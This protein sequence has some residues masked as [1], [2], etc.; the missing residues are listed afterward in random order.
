ML[1][2]LWR[3]STWSHFYV[4][5][6]CVCVGT[7]RHTALSFSVCL[8][9]NLRAEVI[10]PGSSRCRWDGMGGKSVQPETWQSLTKDPWTRNHRKK[11]FCQHTWKKIVRIQTSIFRTVFGLTHHLCVSCF[12]ST[13]SSQ[14]FS[15][16]RGTWGVCCVV[17]CCV[18][19]L[20]LLLRSKG[21]APSMVGDD[22][23][24]CDS[25]WTFFAIRA[26]GSCSPPAVWRDG[27]SSRCWSGPWSAPHQSAKTGDPDPPPTLR[28]QRD[29]SNHSSW[30]QDK[31]P[32]S[33]KTLR[34]HLNQ[35][36]H[37]I[38]WGVSSQEILTH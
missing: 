22:T 25:S 6:C 31:L 13:T 21:R 12:H 8:K 20:N 35:R 36:L 32:H 18:L 17:L 7:M 24:R 9:L 5:I 1:L 4:F 3:F 10:G 14:I 26:T 16:A 30:V 28:E 34:K 33:E 2:V 29:K 11:T 38:H 23:H 19:R 37:Y 27:S 15:T